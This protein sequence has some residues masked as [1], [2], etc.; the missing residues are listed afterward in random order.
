MNY[1][2]YNYDLDYNMSS[3][4]YNSNHNM[5]HYYYDFDNNITSQYL[6]E[7]FEE[8][9]GDYFDDILSP[10]S[11]KSFGNVTMGL[12]HLF[13]SL[14]FMILQI[15]VFTSFYSKRRLFN[16]TCFEIIFNYGIIS[17]IQQ[18]CHIITS[19]ILITYIMEI[20]LVLSFIGTL[21][22]ASYIGNMAFILL[23]TLNHFDIVYNVKFLNDYLKKIIYLYGIILCYILTVII[24]VLLLLLSQC[25]K[26][27][28]FFSFRWVS[29]VVNLSGENNNFEKYFTFPLLSGSLILQVLIFTKI[30][31]LR[32]Y[33][34]KKTIFT[35]DELKIILH[36]FLCFLT[37]SILEL[38]RDKV[39][40]QIRW[41]KLLK[42]VPH[43]LFIIL[44]VSNSLFVLCFVREIR[45]NMPFY[46]YFM[47]KNKISTSDGSV[48]ITKTYV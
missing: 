31:F 18:I 48:K 9:Y 43:I 17:F 11:K 4:Y 25:K 28:N 24:F 37:I 46:K 32:C 42:Y 12:I 6:N 16:R 41:T 36:T 13:L 33:A 39:I 15:L 21:L 30:L 22:T 23:L 20:R 40:F 38:T 7:L 29:C 27:F 26:S 19:I 10:S 34:S 14:F 3:N 8:Y 45:I 35:T 5:S 47:N 1:Y 2:N 44:S